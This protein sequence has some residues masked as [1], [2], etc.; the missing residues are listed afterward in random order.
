MHLEILEDQEC[1]SLHSHL[2]H[3]SPKQPQGAQLTFKVP[4]AAQPQAPW[5]QKPLE[6]SVTKK[7]KE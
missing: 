7:M 3:L 4:T 6:P 5:M 2:Y 1:Q